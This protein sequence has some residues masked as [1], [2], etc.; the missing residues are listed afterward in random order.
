MLT[1]LRRNYKILNQFPKK[2]FT[3]LS[4]RAIPSKTRFKFIAIASTF[5]S[6]GQDC[7]QL[8]NGPAYKSV[9]QFTGIDYFFSVIS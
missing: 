4:P 9:C 1:H 8:Q 6:A 5:Q 2:G 3:E 7:F